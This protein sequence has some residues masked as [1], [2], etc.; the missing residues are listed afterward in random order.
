MLEQDAAA[1]VAGEQSC[2]TKPAPVPL[3]V[4]GNNPGI[5]GVAWSMRAARLSGSRGFDLH[6][7]QPAIL[8]PGT[9]SPRRLRSPVRPV[10]LDC[11]Y[12][13]CTVSFGGSAGSNP[14]SLE[15]E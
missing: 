11:A 1:W 9:S 6:L 7:T 5:A 10:P 4:R 15:E 12:V 14:M 2:G 3:A 13:D 8:F